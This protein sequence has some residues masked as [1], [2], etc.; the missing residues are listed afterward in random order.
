M[1]K[2]EIKESLKSSVNIYRRQEFCN[3]FEFLE[4]IIID[5][6]KVITHSN[7]SKRL[8]ENGMFFD[9]LG[10]DINEYKKELKQKLEKIIKGK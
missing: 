5:M 8:Y 9:S 3:Y 6:Y 4:Q 1:N 7:T 2:Q 10:K